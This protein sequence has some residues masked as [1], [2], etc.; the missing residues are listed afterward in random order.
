MN[1]FVQLSAVIVL[2]VLVQIVFPGRDFY[3]YGW[4]NVL[5]A[6][7]IVVA[8]MQLRGI[9]A[10][11][12]ART[13]TGMWVAAL[14]VA[15]VGVAGI[16]NGLLAPDTQIVIGAPGASVRVDELGRSLDFPLVE[17]GANAFPVSYTADGFLLRPV[18][19]NV[20]EI[21][22]YDNRGAH[23]TITQPT[24]NVFLSPVLT[25]ASRQTIA[26]MNL[27]YDS[28]AIPAVHREVKAVLFDA[29]QAAQLR[30]LSGEPGPAVLFDVEDEGGHELSHGIALARDGQ[31]VPVDDVRLRPRIQYYPA[32]Q[33]IAIPNLLVVGIGLVLI[34]AGVALARFAP[35]IPSYS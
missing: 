11:L 6:A 27:P 26:G 15:L 20:V 10:K 16:A 30:A 22:A 8:L 29:Q 5:L 17:N 33:I 24:G 25:M 21:Q 23:L 13:R 3:H 14:G 34:A 12:P 9:A 7:L 2:T 28:F 1:A 4:F 35:K 31:T 18:P 19:R 32:V